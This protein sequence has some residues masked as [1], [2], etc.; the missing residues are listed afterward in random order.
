VKSESDLTSFL[1]NLLGL[2]VI[3]KANEISEK[4]KEKN[5]K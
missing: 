2:L 5:E 4:R 1:F 3:K